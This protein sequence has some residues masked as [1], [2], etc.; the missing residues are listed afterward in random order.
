MEEQPWIE[1]YRPRLLDDIVGNEEAVERL[2][3]IAEDGNMPNLLLVGPPGVGKTTSIGCLAREI[4]QRALTQEGLPEDEIKGVVQHFMKEAVLELNASDERK[5]DTVR[6]TIKNFA[7]KKVTLPSG[8]H[9]LV[10]LDEA[11]SMTKESQQ[12]LRRIME[13]CSSSTRFALACNQSTGVIEPI[14]SRCAVVR[15]RKLS[16]EEMCLRLTH[17][18]EEEQIT[19]TED[20]YHAIIFCAEGDMRGA[21]NIMQSTWTG[22][23]NVTMENV[24]KV[25]DQPSPAVL[26]SLMEKCIR[27]EV[28]SALSVLRVLTSK[29]GYSA[30]DIIRTLN[31]LV[32]YSSGSLQLSEQQQL[33]LMKEIGIAHMRLAEGVESE[34]QLAGLLARMARSMAPPATASRT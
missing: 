31:R 28:S 27:G 13:T 16:D 15:Y 3:V 18:V 30:T 1:K 32:Q 19:I 8:I 29:Q 26:Q 5:L 20:G 17:V 12:A 25:C 22:F 7:K 24:F 33:T 23:E 14:Q 2:K 11:D 6:T 9:K 34:L 21:L 4:F 10:V